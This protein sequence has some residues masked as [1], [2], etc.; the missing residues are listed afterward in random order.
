MVKQLLAGSKDK[1]LGLLG[2]RIH[3]FVRQ[4]DR[5]GISCSLGAELPCTFYSR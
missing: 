4:K 3:V 1:T 2:F 5:G